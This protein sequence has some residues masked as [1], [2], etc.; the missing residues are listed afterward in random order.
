MRAASG[1]P[2]IVGADLS[3]WQP[4]WNKIVIDI[5]GNHID[6]GGD[7]VVFP[8]A[9]VAPAGEEPSDKQTPGGTVYR[10]A[11]A[12][13]EPSLA[14][15]ASPLQLR[16][17][18]NDIRTLVEDAK[19]RGKIEKDR[20]IQWGQTEYEIWRD[21]YDSGTNPR[22][23]DFQSIMTMAVE[24]QVLMQEN[25]LVA[26]YH[27]MAWTRPWTLVEFNG[28]PIG[29]YHLF[30][31]LIHNF[32]SKLLNFS[33]KNMPTYDAPA[34]GQL[35]EPAKA[36]PILSVCAAQADNGDLCFFAINRDAKRA[37]PLRM[38]ID[39][40]WGGPQIKG[41]AWTLA[42]PKMSS[43]PEEMTVTKGDLRLENSAG[44][45][46]RV[47]VLYDFPARSITVLRFAGTGSR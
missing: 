20:S 44:D 37:M 34:F 11:P 13:I 9:D 18:I 41:R 15:T 40:F 47:S 36:V 26:C 30:D 7:H 46:H 33:L 16:R 32:G 17:W 38:R 3:R 42:A 4:E 24:L 2:I 28:N 25:A 27:E 43:P 8:G 10:D 23:C 31:M 5:V 35:Q 6:F 22:D 19:S 39:S 12:S 1:I 45:P 14:F 29:Q 21:P